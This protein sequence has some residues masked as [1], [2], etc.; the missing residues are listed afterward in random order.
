[1]RRD[2]RHPRGA[3]RHLPQPVSIRGRSKSQQS[4]RLA[5]VRPIS[6]ESRE[7]V[8]LWI[9]GIAPRSLLVVWSPRYYDGGNSAIS[10][11]CEP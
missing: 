4:A 11:V 5:Q 2:E 8:R 6:L 7:A 1:L 9:A 10:A 3:R